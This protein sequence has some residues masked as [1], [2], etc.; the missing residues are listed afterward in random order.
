MMHPDLSE[1]V[2]LNGARS[3]AKLQAART[4]AKSLAPEKRERSWIRCGEKA[5]TLDT[6][7]KELAGT[8][9]A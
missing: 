8:A 9:S 3:F 4:Y 1:G 6:A 7:E 2:T 5:Q